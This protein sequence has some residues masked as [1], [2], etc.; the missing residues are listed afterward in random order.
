MQM[1]NYTAGFGFYSGSSSPPPPLSQTPFNP[2][3][4]SSPCRDAAPSPLNAPSYGSGGPGLASVPLPPYEAPSPYTTPHGMATPA[5]FYPSAIV[6]ARLVVLHFAL[7]VK[8][9]A[10]IGLHDR[11]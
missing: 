5:N 11:G 9:E 6:S 10:V 4:G 3:A 8:A 1:A 2:M 7:Y